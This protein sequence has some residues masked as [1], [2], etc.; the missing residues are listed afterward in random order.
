DFLRKHEG[1]NMGAFKQVRRFGIAILTA[2]LCCPT[3]AQRLLADGHDGREGD[4]PPARTAKAPAGKLDPASAGLTERERLLLDRVEQLERRVA[5][6]EEKG[7]SATAATA[8]PSE[9]PAAN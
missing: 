7:S 1:A 9:Q 8:L 6:L 3:S 5:E 4:N 2:W